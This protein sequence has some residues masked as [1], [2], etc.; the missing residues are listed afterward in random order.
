MTL[1]PLAMSPYEMKNEL[2]YY[3]LCKS[4]ACLSGLSLNAVV[5]VKYLHNVYMELLIQQA[6][7]CESHST[8]LPFM[9][10]S[11]YQGS[12]GMP[13]QKFWKINVLRKHVRTFLAFAFY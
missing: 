3:Q 1:Q 9:H 11:S 12:W 8:S 10:K 5:F 7:V 4:N 2:V 6:M 13:S